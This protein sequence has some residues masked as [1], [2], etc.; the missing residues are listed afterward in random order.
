M[1]PIACYFMDSDIDG[2]TLA[3]SSASTYYNI[4]MLMNTARKNTSIVQ[5]LTNGE[6]AVEESELY[7]ARWDVIFDGQANRMHKI[8]DVMNII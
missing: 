4:P 1:S 7:S 2:F 3:P 8:I 5:K 6:Y